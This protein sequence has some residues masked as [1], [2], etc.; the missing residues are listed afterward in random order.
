MGVPPF[1]ETTI[2]LF[3]KGYANHIPLHKR[4][5]EP[6]LNGR[7]RL[8]R[9]SNASMTRLARELAKAKPYHEFCYGSLGLGGFRDQGVWVW[10]F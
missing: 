8:L 2:Y 1:M 9:F 3:T 6:V 5:R 4:V 10:G 7:R